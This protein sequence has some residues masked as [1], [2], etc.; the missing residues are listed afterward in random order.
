VRIP[1][2]TTVLAGL[3]ASVAIGVLPH[4]HGAPDPRVGL[5]EEFDTMAGWKV[6]RAQ[7]SGMNSEAGRGVFETHIK[8]LPAEMGGVKVTAESFLKLFKPGG[9]EVPYDT[10]DLV[11]YKAGAFKQFGLV[12]LDR[13]RYLVMKTDLR[14]MGAELSLRLAD[15]AS[16]RERSH[17]VQ[18]AHSSGVISQDLRSLGIGGKRKVGLYLEVFSTGR[19]LKVDYIRL[20]SRL[21]EAE[22][23][24]LIPQPIA[25]PA[26]KVARHPYQRLEALWRRASRPWAGLGPGHEEMAIFRDIGTRMPI[27]R[28]TGTPA[29]EGL[30]GTNKPWVWRPD[31]SSMSTPRR[32]YHFVPGRWARE[33]MAR[34]RHAEEATR[35]YAVARDKKRQMVVFSRR[36][37]KTGKSEVIHEHPFPKDR[38]VYG[39]ETAVMGSRMVAALLGS[40]V[41]VVDAQANGGKPKVR[42]WP[43][44]PISAKG[45][46]IDR[47][48]LSYWAPFLSLHRILVDLDT[49]RISKGVHHTMTHGMSGRDW[50]IMSYDGVSKVL[51]SK[52]ARL[53]DTPGRALRVYGIY[54]AAVSTD[55]GEMTPDS[56]YGITNGIRGE[57]DGQYVLF[58]RL[59]AGTVLRLCTYNVSY[60]TWD[61]R[62]KVKASPDYTKLA[63][64]SDMLGD[65]DFYVT[66]IRRPDPPRTVKARKAAAGVRLTWDAPGRHAETRGYNV[67]RSGR[68]GLDYRRVNAGLVAGTE[69][70]DRDPPPGGAYYLVTAEEHSGLASPFTSEISTGAPGGAVICHHEAEAQPRTAPMR[71]YVDGRASGYRAVRVTAVRAEEQAGTITFPAG[72]PRPGKYSIWGRVRH[73]EAGKQ[74]SLRLQA[75]GGDAAALAVSSGQWAWVQAS[76]KVALSPGVKLTLTSADQGA[77]LDKIIV[78][79]AADY[80]P[81]SADDRKAA[82]AAVAGLKV[83]RTSPGSVELA[84]DAGDD[85]DVY[86]YSVYV[87]NGADFRPG[88]ETLLCSGRKTTALDWG[89]RPATRYGYKVVAVDKFGGESPPATI[90]ARTADLEVSTKQLSALG[91]EASGGLARGAEFVEYPGAKAGSQALTF[92]FDLARAGRHYVWIKYTPTFNQRARYDSIGV[93][94]DGGK[95]HRFATRPRPPRG[96]GSKPGRWFHERLLSR[97]DLD[98]GKHS[99]RLVFRDADGIRTGMGQR[100]SGLWVTNDA[101]W[102]PPGYTA[103]VMF[104]TPAPWKPL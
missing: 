3:W 92:R 79:D 35:R 95:V 63:Y 65:A 100:V 83:T 77:M 56:R 54:R 32:T 38:P 23:A 74:G 89:L 6:A 96:Q 14:P 31:G 50:S 1:H 42:V 55:Y 84:W 67:Y 4:A 97:L 68:S 87:G 90:E 51:V 15:P 10:K 2:V 25:L 7:L 76:G 59:D 26:E 20:V 103:Q 18:V 53:S 11:S 37:P 16:G 75:G 66:V 104:R 58:D 69:F 41:V 57:L 40:E 29:H 21:T 44:P 93:S 5:A 34:W 19:K 24:G 80:R 99:I 61:L 17:E 102:A 33:S 94:V 70:T 43:L 82:P 88:N 91:A 47:K 78:T 98:A 13:Y 64:A 46:W 30:T 60:E 85:P 12:D 8:N 49:G 62:A 71:D 45:V 86:C 73:F 36:D 72:V 39:H 48:C 9:P 101:S 22:E 81:R 27:W 52:Q 28:M